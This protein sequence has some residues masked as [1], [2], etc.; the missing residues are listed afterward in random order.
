MKTILH[1]EDNPANTILVERILEAHGYRVVHA[2][3]GE[4]GIQAALASEPD[5]IL[6]DMGLPD[7]DGQTV[8]TLLKQL[9]TLQG[10]P[11]VAITAW[12]P[13]QALEIARRYGLAGCLLKPIDVK[14]FPQQIA[15]FLEGRP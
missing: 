4:S 11:L 15:Q 8:V 12:P 14:T 3:D 13:E 2:A 5:L 6:I 1:I 7:I 10:I 9:P